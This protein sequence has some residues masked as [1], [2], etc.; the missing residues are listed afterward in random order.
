MGTVIGTSTTTTAII[1]SWLDK[2]TSGSP[3]DCRYKTKSVAQGM[4]AALPRMIIRVRWRTPHP[5]F[6][7]TRA[8]VRVAKPVMPLL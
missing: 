8:R 1:T 5:S 2:K 4:S 6:A 7:A 3:R